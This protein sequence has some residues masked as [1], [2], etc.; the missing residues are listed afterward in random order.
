VCGIFQLVHH[1]L[2]DYD[3]TAAPQLLTVTH[4][5]NAR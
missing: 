2:W 4:N 5:G 1:D 3:T